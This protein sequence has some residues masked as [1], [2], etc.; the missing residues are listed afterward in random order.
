MSKA[1]MDGLYKELKETT[2][3]DITTLFRKFDNGTWLVQYKGDKQIGMLCIS[4]EN[5]QAIHNAPYIKVGDGKTP[6]TLK[7]E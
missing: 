6:Q 5:M 3:H 1:N 4:E 7:G 2:G